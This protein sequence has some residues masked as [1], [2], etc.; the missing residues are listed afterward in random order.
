[1]LTTKYLECRYSLVAGHGASHL[2]GGRFRKGN[3]HRLLF[4]CYGELDYR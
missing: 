4:V 1:M 3:L 2:Q